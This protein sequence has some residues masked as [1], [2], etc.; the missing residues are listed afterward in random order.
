MA[1]ALNKLI[2]FNKVIILVEFL[3]DL[4]VIGTGGPVV[5]FPELFFLE[6]LDCDEFVFAFFVVEL[7]EADWAQERAFGALFA[8]TDDL[9]FLVFVFLVHAC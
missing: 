8:E 2:E 9:D 7:S 1:D 5:H 4:K 6:L 3:L